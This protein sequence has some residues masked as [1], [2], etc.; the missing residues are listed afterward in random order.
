MKK[1]ALPVVYIAISLIVIL[2]IVKIVGSRKQKK[3]KQQIEAL[4]KE[5]NEIESAPVISEL[6]KLET[7]AKNDNMEKKYK[8]WFDAFENVRNN[9]NP[10]INDMII[11][12]DVYIEKREYKEYI[13]EY[14]KTEL[15][16]YKAR[17]TTDNLLAAAEGENY[18][19]TDMYVRFAID[20]I[21]DEDAKKDK[22]YIYFSEIPNW[23]EAFK[24][25]MDIHKRTAMDIFNMR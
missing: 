20:F 4:D 8:A 7:I 10:K 23:I 22:V 19:Y 1:V 24:T 11:N 5:K 13:L 16:I 6:A 12:L 9:D 21:K 2:I 15:A 14:A 25:D 18:E 3:Y 17:T